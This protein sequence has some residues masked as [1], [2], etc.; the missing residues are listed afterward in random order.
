MTAFLSF[1]AITKA[2]QRNHLAAFVFVHNSP[3]LLRHPTPKHA[4]QLDMLRVDVVLLLK[5]RLSYREYK[6]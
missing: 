4:M 1:V 5:Q 6:A 3:D 2:E